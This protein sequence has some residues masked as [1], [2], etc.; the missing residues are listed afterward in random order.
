MT[1]IATLTPPKGWKILSHA[2]QQ[3]FIREHLGDASDIIAIA[4]AFV[5][6]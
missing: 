5:L 3:A 1:D 4:L 6:Q 2:E